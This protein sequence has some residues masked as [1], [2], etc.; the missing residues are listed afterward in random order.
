MIWFNPYATCACGA[1]SDVGS[2]MDKIEVERCSQCHPFYTGK[3][4]LLDTAGRVEKFKQRE[5]A[6]EAATKTAKTPKPKV[7]KQ[8]KE[9]TEEV[10]T[11]A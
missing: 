2:T 6:A 1:T 7:D 8:S 10:V 5:A 3:D 9:K 4:K 11:K